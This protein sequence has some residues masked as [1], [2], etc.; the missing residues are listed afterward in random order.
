MKSTNL[1][2]WRLV[3]KFWPTQ[4]WVNII[5]TGK[6]GFSKW[7]LMHDGKQLHCFESW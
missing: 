1:T 3:D 5:W 7:W 6:V 2:I 4:F